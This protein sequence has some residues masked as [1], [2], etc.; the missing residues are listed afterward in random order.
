METTKETIKLPFYARL[1]LSLL[2]VILVIFLLE[3]G[4][5][6]F[7]PLVF[8][9]L[10]AILLYPLN[11]FFQQRLKM[12]RSGAALV[13]LLIFITLL[14][15]FFY[16]ITVQFIN[17]THDLPDLKLRFRHVFAD[18][19]HWVYTKFHVNTAQQTDYINK[20]VS[21]VVASA[22]QSV[23]NIFVSLTGIT[24]L[25]VFVFI[26]SFFILYHRQL[27]MRFTLKLFHFEHQ[28]KVNEV[29]METKSMINSYVVGLLL[30][31]AVMS[32]ANTSLLLIMGIQYAVL[33]GVFA[34]VLNIIP[35]LGIYSAIA[36][37]MFVTF[38]NG[39]SGL[40]LEVGIGLFVLH[41]LDANILMPR[42]V[43]ARVKMN[44]FITVIAVIIGEFVWGIPGMFLFIPITGIIKLVCERV[45]GLEAWGILIG[46]DETEA[47][48]RKK[49]VIKD[50]QSDAMITT[51]PPP[52]AE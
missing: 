21:S 5:D 6:I 16:F 10:I 4:R 18:M 46:V 45:E 22:A 3:Q 1:A 29:I 40:A 17:F 31:M 52:E 50:V 32:V 48:P 23:S 30:E 26:F 41:F 43:G 37:T 15:V 34:A 33:L 24:F 7:V 20:S 42:I 13:S 51:A 47:K 2:S 19:H 38:A 27:L 39:S 12:G 49:L 25:I 36:L 44:P 11:R 35:Y 28:D 14:T 9:L 8:G